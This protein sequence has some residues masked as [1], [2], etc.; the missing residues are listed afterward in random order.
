MASFRD[1]TCLLPGDLGRLSQ[2]AETGGSMKDNA[3]LKAQAPISDVSSAMRNCG[4]LVKS[5]GVLNGC[6]CNGFAA[7]SHPSQALRLEKRRYFNENL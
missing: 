3:L 4:N 1:V 6:Y 5:F 7:A 2:V